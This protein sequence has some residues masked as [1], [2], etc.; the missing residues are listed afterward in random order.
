MLP[1]RAHIGRY[2]SPQRAGSGNP[3]QSS[4]VVV[5][6]VVDVV[7]VVVVVVAVVEV[8]VVIVVVEVEVVMVVV[9]EVNVV[10]VDVVVVVDVTLVVVVVD[11]VQM[12]A[13]HSTGH[14]RRNSTAIAPPTTLQIGPLSGVHFMG[15]G[16]PLHK[17]V[18]VEVAVV[19][20]AVTVVVDVVHWRH[21]TG[22]VF[23]IIVA[24]STETADSSKH[25]D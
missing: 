10:I 11:V 4:T 17:F 15:S 3:L 12:Q 7:T 25:S 14:D 23:R 6:V 19:L 9:V 18:V 21:N 13:L 24:S 16:S 20:V 5:E 2:D 1:L 8:V 22:H